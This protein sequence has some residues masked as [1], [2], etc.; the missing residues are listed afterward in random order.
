MRTNKINKA[1]F[2]RLYVEPYLNATD[3]PY[4]R[5]LW[6][7]LIDQGLKDNSLPKTANNWVYPSNKYFV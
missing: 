3:K 7:D 6:N 1:I 5:Q 2:Y 4:N